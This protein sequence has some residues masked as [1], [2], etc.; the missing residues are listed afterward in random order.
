MATVKKIKCFSDVKTKTFCCVAATQQNN[1]FN[2]FVKH[3]QELSSQERAQEHAGTC[4]NN[5]F[6]ISNYRTEKTLL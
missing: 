3:A 2:H 1:I 6:E 4:S 5:H